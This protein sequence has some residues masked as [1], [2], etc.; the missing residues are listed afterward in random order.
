M[1]S[2]VLSESTADLMHNWARW[3][4]YKTDLGYTPCPMF[5][6]FKSLNWEAGEPREGPPINADAERIESSIALIAQRDRQLAS[7]IIYRWLFRYSV[8][9]LAEHFGNNKDIS[10][11]IL[12]RAESTLE[13]VLWS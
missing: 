10:S 6:E 11:V 13:G 4:R 8:R 2:S 5:K 12:V 3:A 9:R 7:Y 1:Q